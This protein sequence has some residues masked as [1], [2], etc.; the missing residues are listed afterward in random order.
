MAR[1][2][3]SVVDWLLEGDPSIRW[4]ALRDLAGASPRTV[5]RERRKV[6]EEGWGARYLARQDAGGTWA[7]GRSSNDG[8]YSP[9]WISTTYTMLTL[10]DLGLPPASR[11]VRKACAR[12][13]DEG[14]QRDGGIRAQRPSRRAPRRR[15]GDPARPAPP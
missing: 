4:R 1:S 6:G 12:L 11:R 14:L 9:K 5:E 10:R 15:H 3:D 2:R 8:L 7:T 13:L